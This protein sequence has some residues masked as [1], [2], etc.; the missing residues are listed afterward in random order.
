[1]PSRDFRV[2]EFRDQ[3]SHPYRRIDSTVARKNLILRSRDS[4]DLHT[5]LI[6][7]RA[8]HAIALRTLMSWVV[9]LIQDPRYL[10]SSTVSTGI[11]FA[12]RSDVSGRLTDIAL[13]FLALIVR[14][15]S[16]HSFSTNASRVWAWE[17]LSDRCILSFLY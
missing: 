15:I 11:S 8:F 14:P 1:M 17:M 6:S 2:D 4:F 5:A 7:F 9:Q 16:R 13:V 12:V 10:K 3:H